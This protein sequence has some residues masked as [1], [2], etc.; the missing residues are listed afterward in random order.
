M[1]NSFNRIEFWVK[2]LIHI[3]WI[4]RFLRIITVEIGNN[5]IA[6]KSHDFFTN[7][8]LQ[9]YSSSNSNHHNNNSYSN[10]SNT[11]FYYWCRNTTFIRFTINN[12]FSYKIFEFQMMQLKFISFKNTVLLF[13]LCSFLVETFQALKVNNTIK[14]LIR[15]KLVA[16]TIK[17]LLVLIKLKNICLY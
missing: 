8:L 6:I 9:S 14:R 2:I 3:N 13:V 15:Q 4:S 1:S 10:G 5:Y 7:L 16:M 12:A 11:N 17:L